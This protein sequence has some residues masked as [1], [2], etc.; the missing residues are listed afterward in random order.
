[1]RAKAPRA[2]A[3]G[4]SAAS[5]A[6]LHPRSASEQ[7]A[8]P[9]VATRPEPTGGSPADDSTAPGALHAGDVSLACSRVTAPAAW[10]PGPA[11]RRRARPPRGHR[12]QTCDGKVRAAPSTRAL[13]RQRRSGVG[14]SSA[15]PDTDSAIPVTTGWRPSTPSPRSTRG[16]GHAAAASAQRMTARRRR[17]PLPSAASSP[18]PPLRRRHRRGERLPVRVGQGR[19]H[20]PRVGPAILFVEQQR[21]ID[22]CRERSRQLG[23][24]QRQR[25]RPDATRRPPSSRRRSRRRGRTSSRGSA[26]GGCADGLEVDCGSTAF[27][28]TCSGAMNAGVPMMPPDG[29]A[30]TGP[31]MSRATPKSRT[32][33]VPSRVRNRFSG[34]MSR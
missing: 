23:R 33:S 24:H 12:D 26:E 9:P 25:P 11:G 3:D 34:L 17:R 5:R 28:S 30:V 1:M 27:P 29:S 20:G 8:Q 6:R 18:R 16:G 22:D 2:E 4:G 14:A 7:P 32:L 15:A 31:S 19:L 10:C 21:P 13:G